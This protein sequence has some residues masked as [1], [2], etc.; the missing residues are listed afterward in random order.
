MSDSYV[1]YGDELSDELLAEHFMLR[2]RLEG[3]IV[4]RLPRYTQA[5]PFLRALLA[6]ERSDWVISRNEEVVCTVE[7]SRHGYTGDNS[8]QR[9]ARLYRAA[10]LGIPSIYFTPFNRARLNELDEGRNSPRNVAPEL[11]ETLILM[12]E[13]FGV[14]CLAIDWP[15]TTGGTP[16]PLSSPATTPALDKLCTIVTRLSEGYGSE[17]SDYGWIAPEVHEAMRR[18]ASLPYR[19]SE[20]RFAVQLPIDISHTGWIREVLS[21]SYFASGKR[22]KLL[23]SAVFTALARRPIVGQQNSPFWEHEGEAWVLYVGYQWRPDPT[24]GLIALAAA[25]AKRLGLPLIV[26]WPRVFLER[27]GLRGRLLNALREFKETGEGLIREEG[28]RLGVDESSLHE[29]RN[30]VSTSDNQYGIY[31]EDSKVGRILKGTADMVV[32]GDAVL[33]LRGP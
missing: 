8:F 17:S 33:D 27:G 28:R 10:E 16:A 11:F 7:F 22:D 15:I 26:L 29:F 1:I 2:E 23:A 14:P 30:R 19:G 4:Q 13:Q 3:A 18:Q 21:T 25:R 32:F 6:W 12:S 9:F 20:T 24:C 5:P 31:A